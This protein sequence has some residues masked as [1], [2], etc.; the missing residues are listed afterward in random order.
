MSR[1]SF[2]VSTAPT[3][4]PENV[5]VEVTSSTEIRVS[6]EE[7]AEVNKHGVII[8]YEVTYQPLM[9]FSVLRTMSNRSGNRSITIDGL[10]EYV[11][12][13]ISVRAYTREGPGP[14]SVGIVSR[15]F[16]DGKLQCVTVFRFLFN[17]SYLYFTAPTSPPQN[18]SLAVLTSSE[19]QVNWT[20]I[21]EID[22][23]GII[24]MYE[25]MYAGNSITSTLNTTDLSITLIDVEEYVPYNI[26][27]RAYTSVGPGPYSEGQIILTG[28]DG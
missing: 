18:I 16:E 6:W 21:Y 24:V 2:S 9:T 20:E 19:I 5:S 26:S 8:E 27:V 25:V 17:A 12:Y 28:E 10:E 1:H 7:V 14:Y 11:E 15:T 4:P 13:N 3:G 23:N 22:Q